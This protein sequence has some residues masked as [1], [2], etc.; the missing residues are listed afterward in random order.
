MALAKG[1]TRSDWLRRP[2]SPRNSTTPPTTCATCSR[3]TT[4]STAQAAANSVAAN[5]CDEDGARTGRNADRRTGERWPHLSHAQPRNSSMPRRATPPAAPAAL[6]RRLRARQRPS[7]QLD[8]GQRIGHRAG[9]H[10]ADRPSPRCKRQLDAHPEGAAQPGRCDVAA[11][12][13]R[14]WPTKPTPRGRAAKNATSARCASCRTPSRRAAPN[15]ACPT[16]CWP[17]GAGWRHC[18]TAGCLTADC[19]ISGRSVAACRMAALLPTTHG[20]GRSQAGVARNCKRRCC[21]RDARG[22]WRHAIS[23]RILRPCHGAVAQL[24]ERHVRIV[25]VVGSIPIRSTTQGSA[26]HASLK[27]RQERGFSLPRRSRDVRMHAAPFMEG[28]DAQPHLSPGASR[29]PLLASGARECHPFSPLAGR[30][31][32]RRMRGN[33]AA[34]AGD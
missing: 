26:F 3:C 29:H 8:P 23:L 34:V 16:A 33:E 32:R 2:L 31:C 4:C 30:R 9:A 28:H 15:S 17:R 5:G 10:A 6:A 25:E 7:A 11:L 12:D 20:P 27:P 18:L 13:A 24:G 1:E 21:P 22:D 19:L 14:R